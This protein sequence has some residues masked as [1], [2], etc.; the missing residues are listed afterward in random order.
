MIFWPQSPRACAPDVA[1]DIGS[2]LRRRVELVGVFVNQPLDDVQHLVE[3]IPLSA[4]QLHGEEGPHYATEIKRRTGAKVIKAARVRGGDDVQA[5]GM[6]R[7]VDYHLLDTHHEDLRGGTGKTFDWELAHRRPP[8][9]VPLIL[10]GGLTPENVGD[11]IRVA[12]PYAVDVASGVESAPGIKDHEKLAAFA[13]AV[14]ATDE[15]DHA[16]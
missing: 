3:T 11:A 15:V 9:R 1:R 13:A 7:D 6:F 8:T 12:R 5:V 4:I 2:R 14:R 16:A 10:S